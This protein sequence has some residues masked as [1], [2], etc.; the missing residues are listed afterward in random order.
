VSDR[1]A[2]DPATALAQLHAVVPARSLADGKA[3][4]GLALDA[5]E[6]AAIVVGLLRRTVEMVQAHAQLAAVHVV[7]ADP[8]LLELAELLGV[9]AVNEQPGPGLA[10]TTSAAERLNAALRQ[11]RAAAIA[12]GA[13]GVLYLPADLPMLSPAALMRLLDA[14]DAALA[15]GAGRPI[16]VIAPAEARGGSNAVLLVPPQV[17]E[18]HFGPISLAAHL[19]AAAESGASVQLVADPELGFDLD[20]P[21]DLERLDPARLLEIQALGAATLDQLASTPPLVATDAR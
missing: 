6:R 13:R 11:G 21:D 17:I 16:V 2:A 12:A 18:P 4:L 9:W 20:T 19:R 10:G 8:A 5:E 15:A 14:A 1:P 3:R 7:S